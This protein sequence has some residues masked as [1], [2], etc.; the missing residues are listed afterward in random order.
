MAPKNISR[1]QGNKK[2]VAVVGVG[3]PLEYKVL[4]YRGIEEKEESRQNRR[5]YEAVELSP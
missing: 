3:P 5:P 1:E 4:Y 2:P